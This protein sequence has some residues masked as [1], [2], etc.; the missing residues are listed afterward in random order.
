MEKGTG[1]NSHKVQKKE[2]QQSRPRGL[3]SKQLPLAQ[4]FCWPE[5]LSWWGEGISSTGLMES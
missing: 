4:P 1:S 3:C 2:E 5:F